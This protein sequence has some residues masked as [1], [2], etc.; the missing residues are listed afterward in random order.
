MDSFLPLVPWIALLLALAALISVWVLYS[1]QTKHTTHKIKRDPFVAKSIVADEIDTDLLV[2]NGIAFT[3]GSIGG[4]CDCSGL[5][6]GGGGSSQAPVVQV[7]SGSG[8]YVAPAGA[9]YLKLFGIGGGAGGQ[10][11]S[12]SGDPVNPAGPGGDTTF[13]DGSSSFTAG[14]APNNFGGVFAVVGWQGYGFVGNTPYIDLFGGASTIGFGIGTGPQIG[15][16]GNGANDS[17]TQG[18]PGGAG[19]IGWAI[20]PIVGS[21]SFSFQVGSAGAA[22]TV[23]P[24]SVGVPGTPGGQ[25]FLA[26]EAYF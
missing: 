9:K 21:T 23:P 4:S 26:V 12:S 24:S 11:A 14:G 10:A 19:S 1:G 7:L 3:G 25:G 8:T 17:G 6:G 15:A 20:V 18:A 13:S 5:T 2:L 16:G 22:G